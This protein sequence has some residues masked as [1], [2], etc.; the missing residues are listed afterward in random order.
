MA[1]SSPEDTGH[2][3][4][5]E[6]VVDPTE[7]VQNLVKEVVIRMDALREAERQ[8][9]DDLREAERRMTEAE[10]RHVNEQMQLRASYAEKLEVAESKR[11]DAI[12]LVDTNAVAIANQRATE[13]AAV[14]ASQVAASAET[15]RILNQQT[16]VAAKTQLDQA[17]QQLSDRITKVE[18]SQYEGRST[19]GT[20]SPAIAEQLAQLQES[21]YRSEGRSGLSAPLLMMI[22][23]LAGG[24][25]IFLIEQF[26]R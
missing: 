4:A 9:F 20:I 11:I 16:A 12:R 1:T 26:V 23:A 18:Q 6:K 19:A 21:R 2:H 3:F 13:Q 24:L 22:A 15:L 14:L 5:N 17:T 25:I 7:N 8:R 10:L